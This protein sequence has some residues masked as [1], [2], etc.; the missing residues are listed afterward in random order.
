MGAPGFALSCSFVFSGCLYL[1]FEEFIIL[2]CDRLS[3]GVLI[4]FTAEPDNGGSL[5]M[6]C[7]RLGDEVQL[8]KRFLYRRLTVLTHHSVNT[9]DYCPGFFTLLVLLRPR[10]LFLRP[11]ALSQRPLA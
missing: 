7:F 5:F 1:D 8:F 11:G 3:Y 2:V 4:H 6:A 9:E 10:V